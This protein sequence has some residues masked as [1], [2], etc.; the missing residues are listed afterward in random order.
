MGPSQ[1]AIAKVGAS[2]LTTLFTPLSTGKQL[3]VTPKPALRGTYTSLTGPSPIYTITDN[4]APF[5]G[6]AA[7]AAVSI[8]DRYNG[9]V[10]AI[11]VSVPDSKTL[12]VYTGNSGLYP[13]NSK[14]YLIDTM[15]LDVTSG[16]PFTAHAYAGA[17]LWLQGV[18]YLVRDNDTT[19]LLLYQAGSASSAPAALA[20]TGGAPAWL[21]TGLRGRRVNGIALN[22]SGFV[23]ATDDGLALFDGA[24]WSHLGVR[25]TSSQLATGTIGDFTP[26]TVTCSPACNFTPD[27]YKGGQL[28]LPDGVHAIQGNSANVISLSYSLAQERPP[29]IGDT[30]VVLDGKGLSSEANDVAVDGSTTWV[31]FGNGLLKN[32]GSTWS[33]FN[34]AN[35]ESSPGKG[36][37][38]PADILTSAAVHTAGELWVASSRSGVARLSGSTWKQFTAAGTESSPFKGDGLPGDSVTR[39]S[40]DGAKT[41]FAGYG[42]ASFDGTSWAT[43][44]SL[45]YPSTCSVDAGCRVQVVV[46][47]SPGVNWFGTGYG[48][49]RIAP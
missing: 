42:A 47:P 5:A 7:G 29:L 9:W 23:A 10:T 32:V 8:L 3:Q 48:L 30:F 33:L 12:K 6:L 24:N 2:G 35:T 43:V 37:G 13:D 17:Q 28:W 44:P 39:F 22:G 27:A 15:R 25:E 45:L 21:L 31:P 34:A 49:V 46:I 36:D 1:A 41:W 20:D 18:T 26:Y 11:V 40:F 19:S 38:L 16:G 4:A 14:A